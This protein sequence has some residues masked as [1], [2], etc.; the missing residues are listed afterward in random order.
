VVAL[1][2]AGV[3]PVAWSQ[4]RAGEQKRLFWE[5]TL[6]S[7][8]RRAQAL[9]SLE[10]LRAYELD[11]PE[12]L[13]TER[14][15]AAI[16]LG[17]LRDTVATVPLMDYLE[18]DAY[19]S[20]RA[21]AAYALGEIGDRRALG[22]LRKALGDW[23]MEVRLWAAW[24][25]IQFGEGSSDRVMRTLVAIARGEGKEKWDV[26]GKLE[27]GAVEDPSR[28][29]RA[30]QEQRLREAWRADAVY[31]LAKVGTQEAWK[32]VEE[33]AADRS[34]DVARQARSMLRHRQKR[35]G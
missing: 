5:D 31:L 7:Q 15:Q 20:V 16:T 26:R 21:C 30:V 9:R 13:E 19:P 24:A 10:G 28:P 32:V 22:V 27:R 33:L 4:E 1:V 14:A 11:D 6:S 3:A 34:E 23:S 18:H 17:H 25:L 2:V 35:G 12:F 29:P 8:A